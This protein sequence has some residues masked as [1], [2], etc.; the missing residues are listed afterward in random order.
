MSDNKLNYSVAHI[1]DIVSKL[2][3]L[4]NFN[5]NEAILKLGLTHMDNEQS[6]NRN[7]RHESNGKNKRKTKIPLP[8]C[9]VVNEH[10]CQGIRYN[11]ALYTQCTNKQKHNVF[12]DACHKQAQ[13][14]SS[15]KPTHGLITERGNKKAMRYRNLLKKLDID[16]QDALAA[17]AD[18][19]V[20]IPQKELEEERVQRGRPRNATGVVIPQ[21]KLEEERVQRGRPRKATG[22]A[23]TSDEDSD[24]NVSVNS[25][26]DHSDNET[27]IRVCKT[28]IGDKLYLMDE[29]K[30]LYDIDTHELVGKCN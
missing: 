17:A 29:E 24:S 13:K 7:R 19:G 26:A 22:V 18:A 16:I 21:K 20:V 11:H 14:N 30:N 5:K 1:E 9:D 6:P 10:L 28:Q 23:D 3:V 15:R 12:C 4:Y 8:F 2:S 25:D 27:S